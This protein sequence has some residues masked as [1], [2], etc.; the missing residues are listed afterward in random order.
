MRFRPHLIAFAAITLASQIHAQAQ[1]ASTAPVKVERVE[2]TGSMIK[3]TDAETP[4]P[5]SVITHDDIVRS[6]ANSVEELLR[7]NSAAGVGGQQDLSTGNGWATG[8]S[9]ISLRGMGSAA[10]LTLVNGRRIAPAAAVDPNTGQG[11]IFNVSSIPM[12]A[13]ER[14]EILKDGASALYGSDALAGVVNIILKRDYTGK[15]IGVTAGQR[16][17]GLFKDHTVNASWG[18]GDQIKDGY[19]VFAALDLYKRDAVSIGEALNLVDQATLGKLFGRYTLNSSY[20]NP[21]NFYTYNNGATGTYKGT[22]ANCPSDQVYVSGTTTRC[23]YNAYGDDLVYQGAQERTGGLLRGSWD[24][25]KG[26]QLSAELLASRTKSTYYS[27]SSTLGETSTTWGNGQGQAVTYSGLV[28]PANHPDNPT[29]AATA[30]NPVFGYTT[31]TALG[32][33]YRFTDIPRYQTSTVD[34]VRAVL[35]AQFS[36]QGWDWD[37]GFLTH[38][39]HT[40]TDMFGYLSVSGINAAVANQTY[41]FGGTNSA[42]VIASI[43]PEVTNSGTARTTSVDLRGSREVG[44]MAGGTAMLGVGTELRHEYFQVGADDRILA[45]DI[46]GLGIAL[47]NG[48]RN[49]AAAYAELQAPLLKD[50]ETQVAL[51][52]EHY[53]DFGAAYTGKL[54]AKYKLAPTLAVRGTLANGFRAPS[55][56]QV[57]TSNVFAFTT[58]QDPVLCPV[59]SSANTNCAKSVSSVIRANPN[60][61]PERSSSLTLGFIATPVEGLELTVDGFIIERRNEVD[62]LSAQTVLNRESEFAAQV[63]RN[64]AG[65]VTQVIR[66]YRNMA[67]TTVAGIDWES[68]YT[69]KFGPGKVKFS[70]NGTRTLSQKARDEADKAEYS[71]LGYYGYTR[72]R[73]NVGVAYTESDWSTSLRANYIGAMKSYDSGYSCSSTATAAGRYDLCS[74]RAYWTTDW[75]LSYTGFKGWRLSGVLK[76]IEGRQPPTDVN[77]YSVGYN[78]SLYDVR[79]RN[80]S[81]SANYEF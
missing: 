62:R 75:S 51:R 17:D 64:S 14:I 52:A 10:T 11:N 26:V 1:T 34:N 31:P 68:S 16:F 25:P 45:G 21:G 48:S 81:V 80:F 46:Y 42:A 55:L 40:A 38:W 44:R 3:R 77:Y 13:I 47:A 53:S 18:V 41:R 54:G 76:N 23:Y 66:Q 37:A 71:N 9:S 33:R 7:M 12:S 69:V 67:S 6:G 35:N 70:Y 63:I 32:L 57:S 60:L 72:V 20:S 2:I 15:S 56:S 4:A 22:G 19:N 58:I 8:T 50:L 36:W 24:L 61:K 78:A 74:I 39:Q 59:Y 30:T 27:A 73:S 65:E 43:S 79:G 5:I 49:V 29:S 28:L